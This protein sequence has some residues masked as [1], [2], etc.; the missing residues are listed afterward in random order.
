MSKQSIFHSFVFAALAILVAGWPVLPTQAQAPP[1]PPKGVPMYNT[2]T[3]T[4]V[5]GT[6]EAVNQVAGRKGM[7]GT[8]LTLKTER[9]TLDVHAG[10]S[11]FLAE[12]QM[13]FAKGDSIEVTGSRAKIGETETLIA[14]E[15]KKGDKTLTL[16]NAQGIPV[17]S[18]GRRR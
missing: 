9:E 17:W 5:T 11:W 18:R 13:E 16:R 12:K 7:A 6:V 8:H 1:G 15:I 14:R 4:T 10:P 2:A 3:E